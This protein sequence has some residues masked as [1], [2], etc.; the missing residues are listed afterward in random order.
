MDCD[1]ITP[2]IV[3]KDLYESTYK[4]LIKY[5]LTPDQ[6]SRKANIYC[7]KNTWRFCTS[8]DIEAKVYRLMFYANL[9]QLDK[10]DVLSDEELD[11]LLGFKGSQ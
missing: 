3:Y 5:G 4:D 11:K 6:A 9:S 1:F 2:L 8:E 10:V 7:V